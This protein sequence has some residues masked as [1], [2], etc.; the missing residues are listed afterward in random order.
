[1]RLILPM[2]TNIY[3]FLS[4][5]VFRN[6]PI[7]AHYGIT[8]RCNLR[9][10]MCSIYQDAGQHNELSVEQI[11]HIFTIL[12]SLGLIY[13]SIGG[14]EPLLRDDLSVIIRSLREK[15][16]MVRLLTNGILADKGIIKELV[17]AGLRDVSISLDTLDPAKQDDIYNRNDSWDDIKKALD[18]FAEMLPRRKRILINTVVSPFNILELPALSQF[19]EKM[20]CHISFIPIESSSDSRFIFTDED[21]QNIDKTYGALIEAKK[22]GRGNIFNSVRFLGNSRQYLK[23]QKRNWACDAGN[24][25]LS[26]NPGGEFSICHKY[27]PEM[28]INDSN[29]KE[30]FLSG[31]FRNKRSDLI[32]HCDGCLRPCWA[33]TSFLL[34]DANCLWEMIRNKILS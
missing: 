8:H 29:F 21:C 26:I 17:S 12:R 18:L 10:R 7:Y 25:Y 14:G 33:E 27:K 11:E 16:L 13:V 15:G 3:K 23:S 34:N 22:K 6:R 24:L 19:A 2:I 4:A 9:C 5:L 1:M 31:E 20:G 28:S 32:H 30:Y